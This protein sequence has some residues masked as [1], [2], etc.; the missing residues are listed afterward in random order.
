MGYY[1]LL[2]IGSQH[3]AD[4]VDQTVNGNGKGFY[5]LTEPPAVTPGYANPTNNINVIN[6]AYI[7]GGMNIHFQTAFG[8]GQAPMIKYG[9][10]PSDL[11]MTATGS[12]ST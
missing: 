3:L 8:L 10:T 6:M 4:W 1:Y 11:S 7:P 12:S 9:N 2:S 5:R